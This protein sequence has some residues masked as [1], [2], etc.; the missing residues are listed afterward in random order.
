MRQV[1][2]TEKYRAVLE[3]N[4]AKGE[5]VRQ[6]RLAHPQHITQFNG[7]DDSVQILKNR[8]LLFE[9]KKEVVEEVMPEPA[10]LPYNDEAFQRGIRYELNAKGIE[11][12]AGANVRLEDYDA[13]KEAAHKNLSKDPMHYLNLISGESSKV[14]KHDKQVE[15]KRGA[16]D[17]DT[18]NGLKK[19]DLRENKTELAKLLKEGKLEDLA[20]KLGVSVEKLRGAADKIKDMERQS[21]EKDALKLAKMKEVIDE[22][23][24]EIHEADGLSID[25]HE[26]QFFH[27]AFEGKYDDILEDYMSSESYK[28]DEKEI[29]NKYDVSSAHDIQYLD[30]WEHFIKEFEA[31]NRDD[32][33]DTYNF[34]AKGIDE[35]LSISGNSEEEIKKNAEELLALAKKVGLDKAEIR[36]ND[37]GSVDGVELNDTV[38]DRNDGKTQKISD[39][40]SKHYHASKAGSPKQ[41]PSFKPKRLYKLTIAGKTYEKGDLD[42]NDDG[43]IMSIEKYPNGYF[44]TGGVYSDYGDGD[45]P[46]EGYGYAIDLKGNEMDEEDLEGM[47]NEKKEADFAPSPNSNIP[48]ANAEEY[49]VA[50]AFKKAGVDM[51]KP[52]MVI[53]SYGSASFGGNDKDEMSAEAAIKKLEAERQDRSKQYTDDGEEVPE[54]HHGYEFENNSVLEEDMPEGHEYKLGYFQLG[55]ADFAITQEKSGVSEK[56]GKDLDGDGDIDG[57][58]YKHAKD[59]AI[60][61]AM[62]KDEQL[63]EAIKKIIKSSLLNEAATAKLSDIGDK[64][65]D[66]KGMQVVINDLENIVTDMEGYFSK[67]RE[68]VQ[69]SMDKIGQ[70][71]TPDGMK[72]GAFLAPAIESAFFRDLN[73]V[74]KL[75]AR[76][77]SLPQV[78]TISSA[79]I[80]AAKA[81]GDIEEQPKQ[82]MFGINEKGEFKLRKDL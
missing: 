34:E 40:Q 81:A 10:A 79:D 28:Q 77:I 29:Q 4:M 43:R 51:S 56:K 54:D 70:I 35:M 82:T 65:G 48:D 32:A 80:A 11:V 9:I 59:K 16:K 72:V 52:V 3:G 25:E 26:H 13:A 78:K 20:N 46:K 1:T 57:D 64:Y 71:E 61:K 6:M 36:Y 17:V 63:K 15:T 44:I 18:F 47:F 30:E 69:S 55:D 68:R 27:L 33:T 76:D 23:E 21:A 49:D 31:I 60:K 66:Y 38:E 45:G 37:D 41:E 62:G 67:V 50:T 5:F 2:V 24:E 73:P 42:P 14:D 74:R 58:D 8:G 7:F 75:S 19:A 39:L 53:H 22:E 12:H